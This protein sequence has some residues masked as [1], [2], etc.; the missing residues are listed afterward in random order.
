[1]QNSNEKSKCNHGEYY[2]GNGSRLD[3]PI[4]HL[5]SKVEEEC[6]F[7]SDGELHSCISTCDGVVE[8]CRKCH[9]DICS[10]PKCP[11]GKYQKK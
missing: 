2:N 11:L 6:E 5:P 3:C 10:N 1:M 7:E 4:C 8:N 9:R